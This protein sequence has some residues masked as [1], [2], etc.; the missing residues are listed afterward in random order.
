[1]YRFQLLQGYNIY[2][3]IGFGVQPEFD[4]DFQEHATTCRACTL[5]C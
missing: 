3:S 2:V 4:Q 1:M 5:A